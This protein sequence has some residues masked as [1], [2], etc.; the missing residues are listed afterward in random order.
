[1]QIT[2]IMI[3]VTF[4]MCSFLSCIY[5]DNYFNK[6]SNSIEIQTN[7]ILKP[8]IFI[9][10]TLS[11]VIYM[12]TITFSLGMLSVLI[13]VLSFVAFITYDIKAYYF[14]A[15]IITLEIICMIML[16]ST[17][18]IKHK[19]EDIKEE[20]I[21]LN[22][23]TKSSEKVIIIE[24]NENPKTYSIMEYEDSKELPFNLSNIESYEIFESKSKKDKIVIVTKSIK[25]D[26]LLSYFKFSE[27][28]ITSY[29]SYRVYLNKENVKYN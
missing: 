17:N 21:Y 9:G 14:T 28:K 8:L 23:Y 13:C 15:V 16:V 7:D 1:M 5:I 19:K 29:V 10:L 20:T 12:F 6:K 24:L 11:I 2:L 22:E 27:P 26:S 3:I 4:L 18:C 25:Y